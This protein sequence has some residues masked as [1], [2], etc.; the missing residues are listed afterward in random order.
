MALAFPGQTGQL[1]E[2]MARDSFVDALADSELRIRTLE[3]DPSTLEE[4]LKI[5]S[6]LEALGHHERGDR[7]NNN[8]HCRNKTLQT[9]DRYEPDN[10]RLLEEIQSASRRQSADLEAFR[11]KHYDKLSSMQRSIKSEL[12]RIT[13]RVNLDLAIQFGPTVTSDDGPRE[14]QIPKFAHF[15][16]LPTTHGRIKTTRQSIIVTK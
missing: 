13:N 15:I 2:I 11:Q 16:S 14:I 7:W 6:R 3:R 9:A 4:A 1:C 5:A 10:S 8:G 12:D